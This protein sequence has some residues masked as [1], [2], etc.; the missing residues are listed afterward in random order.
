MVDARY[1]DDASPKSRT[2]ALILAFFLGFFGV[3][4]FYAGRIGWGLAFFFTFGFFTLGWLVDVFIV[5]F[6]RMKDSSGRL[7]A[8]W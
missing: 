7:I 1:G 3:H 8:R 5:A 4:R 2:I 6:G